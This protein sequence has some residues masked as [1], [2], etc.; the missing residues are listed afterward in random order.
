MFCP[1]CG[2]ENQA[3]QRF[4]R[5]CGLK[6]GDVAN[7]VA[8]LMPSAE[9]AALRKRKR[10]VEKVGLASLSVAGLIALMSVLM[11]AALYKLV[12][13]GPEALFWATGAALT[14]FVLLG[15]SLI[16]YS[17]LFMRSGAVDPRSPAEPEEPAAA[18]PT[19]KLL[20]DRYFEP[21]PSVTE[22]STEL[23]SRKDTLK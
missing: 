1:N 13:F 23:L 4:C 22:R 16:G 3:G 5:S 12:L 19:G 2:K 17:K 8:E 9:S 11:A 21:A 15:V 14:A 6:L 7:M 10:L 20:E 18:A